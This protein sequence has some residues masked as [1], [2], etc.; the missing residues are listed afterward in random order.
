MSAIG[1]P[2]RGDNMDTDRFSILCHLIITMTVLLIYVFT[3]QG[4]VTMQTVVTIVVGYWFGS[5][6][7][8][9]IKKNH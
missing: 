2:N 4:D 6:G 8:G 7:T 5:M 3:G 9:A 1:W